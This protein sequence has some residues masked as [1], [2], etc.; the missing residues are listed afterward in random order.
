MRYVCLLL[1]VS[2]CVGIAQ[3]VDG[4]KEQIKADM[5]ATTPAQR[6]GETRNPPSV[7]VLTPLD[8]QQVILFDPN[9]PPAILTSQAEVAGVT[10]VQRL[11]HK[12]PK[13]AKKAFERAAKLSKTHKNAEAAQALEQ[14]VAADPG[15]ADAYINLG[16]Q[17]YL[18]RRPQDAEK[19][20]RRA[21]EL[22][23]ASSAGYSNLAAVEILLGD[24]VAAEQHARRALALSPGNEPAKHLLASVY[25]KIQH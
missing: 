16:A 14:A 9:L 6:G 11:L 13:Q 4:V 20:L 25:Q 22:D 21:I 17:Y 5:Q 8:N 10:S 23:P 15:F 18:L 2:T 3:E 12:V 1:V 24:L 7:P 19:M